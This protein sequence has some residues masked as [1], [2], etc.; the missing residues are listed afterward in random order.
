[1]SA[2]GSLVID[3]QAWLEERKKGIGASEA[4][5]ALGLSPFESPREL[6]LRKLGLLPE[7]EETEA[8]RLGTLMEPVIAEEYTRRTGNALAERQ[9][10]MTSE[11]TPLLATLDAITADG[12]PVEFKSVGNWSARHLG[13][14]GTDELPEH[15]LIQAHQ[16]MF[17]ANVGRMDFAVL[18]AGQRLRIFSVERDESLVG[19]LIDNLVAFWGCVLRRD[20][21]ALDARADRRIMHVLYPD[22]KGEIAL[23]EDEAELVERLEEMGEDLR[24]IVAGREDIQ[25]RLLDRLGNHAAGRLPDGRTLR[26]SIVKLEAKVIVRKPST[27]TRLWL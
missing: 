9:L 5:A 7:I 12:M 14:E 2:V 22:C 26:R 19:A 4:A 3:R 24:W 1:M 8:M 27:Y 18:V 23:G 25:T 21:P 16:Q 17:L 6:Y 20:C 11:T 10:F 15:W 13:G